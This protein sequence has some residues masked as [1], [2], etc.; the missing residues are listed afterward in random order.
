MNT[1]AMVLIRHEIRILSHSLCFG[2]VVIECGFIR[3]HK[4]TVSWLALEK[5][6]GYLTNFVYILFLTHAHRTKI[7]KIKDFS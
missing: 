5:T 4:A 3:L 1:D 6:W 7:V 2:V